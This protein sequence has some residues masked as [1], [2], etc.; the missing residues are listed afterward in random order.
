VS[1]RNP[2]LP[3]LDELGAEFTALVESTFAGER[4]GGS[5]DNVRR[6]PVDRALAPDR[7]T[8][9]RRAPLPATPPDRERGIQ[10]RRI[11]RRA[12]IV[13]VLLCAVG[14]VAF[15]ALRA[16]EGGSGAA[17]HTAPTQ[18]GRAVDGAWRF[19]AY[20]DEGRLC[21]VLVPRG[22][23]L[24]GNCG[25]APQRGEV[26]TDSAIENGRRYLFGV[27]GTGVARVTVASGSSSGDTGDIW[28][29][30][31]VGVRKPVDRAAASDA[32]F[33]AG[34]GWFAVDLGP[35]G[36]GAEARAPAIVT[37]LD[38]RGH[39]A[40]APYVDCSLGVIGAACKRRIAAAAAR[41]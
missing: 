28:R 17:H 23:E 16:G 8:A 30:A 38:A 27:A 19:S 26:R 24:S 35:S 11:T 4:A 29:T 39:R 2:D 41:G 32:G 25:A 14:G 37:P 21:T 18:L 3:I 12:A 33:P 40:G 22:G 20:R 9:R 13:L 6:L 31:G 10:A 7:H 34:D 36:R 15:A 1:G 5:L